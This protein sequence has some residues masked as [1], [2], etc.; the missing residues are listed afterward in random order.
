MSQTFTGEVRDGV[1]VLD[2]GNPP[3]PEGTRVQVVTVEDQEEQD[4]LR[5]LLLSIAGKA[6]GLPEDLSAQRDLRLQNDDETPTLA[7]RLASVIGTARGLPADL[8]EQHD[9]YLHG[10]PKR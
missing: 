4:A 6:V 8:A 3:L 9:H 10:T 7:D 5:D 1:V 2:P